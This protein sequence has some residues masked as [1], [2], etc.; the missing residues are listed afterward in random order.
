MKYYKS[1]LTIAGS[2]PSGGAGVQADL[3]V[4]TCL[5]CYGQA[6]PTALTVQNTLG[7][8]RSVSVDADLIHDQLCAV[9]DDCPPDVIKIGI[10][11]DAAVVRSI[12]RALCRGPICPVVYDPVMVSSSGLRLMDD[13]AIE[14]VRT[15]LAPHCMLI[16]PNLFEARVWLNERSSDCGI[17]SPAALAYA[18]SEQTGGAVLVKGGHL[19]GD[20]V[21]TLYCNEEIHTYRAERVITCNTHGTGC[22]LSSAIASYYAHGKDL[23]SA[24]GDAKNFIVHALRKG[25]CYEYGKGH[26]PLYLLPDLFSPLR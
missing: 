19:E 11:P 6:I 26:G 21:D 22:A 20:P 25:A 13:E 18:L 7:V 3:K 12:V 23:I 24:V 1:C 4:F 9:L 10:L 2:D 15:E 14:A 16:T 17:D 5:G 8:S